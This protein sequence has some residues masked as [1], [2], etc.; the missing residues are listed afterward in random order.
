[1]WTF[2]Q[3]NGLIEDFKGFRYGCSYA[4]R[5][6]GKNNPVLQDVRAGC[7][8]DKEKQLWLPVEGLTSDDWGPLPCGIY[9][10]QAPVDS[11]THG[12]YV[13]WL[14]PDPANEMFGRSGF[15]CHGD[16]LEHP[17]FA[18]EGCICSPRTIRQVMWKS[19]D[20]RV[21]VVR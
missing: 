5:G 7:R 1:M 6:E 20:H 19:D 8:W 11:P 16:A 15:G 13:L 21:Q 2:H 9:A 18:S 17:G 12:P 10:M 14:T 4:G 3:S